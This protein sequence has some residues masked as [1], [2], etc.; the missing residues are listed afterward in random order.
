MTLLIARD[1]LFSFLLDTSYKAVE[2][3]ERSY[4]PIAN[5]EQ[6]NFVRPLT[7]RSLKLSHG[8]HDTHFLTIGL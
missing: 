2:R 3:S 1:T 6:H 8:S 4:E 5:M 7:T